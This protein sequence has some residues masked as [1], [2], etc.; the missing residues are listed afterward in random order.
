MEAKSSN[1]S[2]VTTCA[3]VVAASC[4][5]F[6]EFPA[7]IR[8]KI[9][10]ELQQNSDN[11]LLLELSKTCRLLRRECFP[12][13]MQYMEVYLPY[14]RAFNKVF[15]RRDVPGPADRAILDS[16]WRDL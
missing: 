4:K 16:P 11:L 3:G 13:A 5:G 8:N 10:D 12:L 7:E 2:G 15:R 6:V 14:H 1:L 9:Y